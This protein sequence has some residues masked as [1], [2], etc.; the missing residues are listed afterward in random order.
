MVMKWGDPRYRNYKLKNKSDRGLIMFEPLIKNASGSKI[1]DEVLRFCTVFW[2]VTSVVTIATSPEGGDG[3]DERGQDMPYLIGKG[4]IRHEALT[5]TDDDIEDDSRPFDS[6]LSIAFQDG[7][8]EAPGQ[9]TLATKSEALDNFWYGYD[10]GRVILFGLHEAIPVPTEDAP[11]EEV[12]EFKVKRNGELLSLRS[13][14]EELYLRI[15]ES[16][17]PTL[18]R[19]TAL[20]RVEKDCADCIKAARSTNLPFQLGTIQAKLDWKAG[21]AAM[22]AIEGGMSLNLPASS[23][24]LAAVSAVAAATLSLTVQP[25][26]SRNSAAPYEYVLHMHEGWR[27]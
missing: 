26:P 8:E 9:W 25:R 3:P 22:A 7:E 27:Y 23:I 10:P 15:V 13:H 21:L 16:P 18:A 24:A 20:L 19:N 2:D 4:V 14:L 11:L 1:D 12:L 17:D 5:L 6:L